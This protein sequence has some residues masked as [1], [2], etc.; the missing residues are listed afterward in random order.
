MGPP[1]D[2]IGRRRSATYLRTK[3]V[4]PGKELSANFA[5]VQLTTR[6][7]QKVSGIRLNEDTWSIQV[8]EMNSKIHSLWKDDL[9][10]LK[11]EQRTMMPSYRDKLTSEELEDIVAHLVQMRGEL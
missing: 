2:G 3:L 8:R 10:E 1:L 9:S 4:N 7:G 5:V 6:S 11:V